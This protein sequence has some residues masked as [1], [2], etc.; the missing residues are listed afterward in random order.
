MSVV[1]VKINPEM[2]PEHLSPYHFTQTRGWSG[3]NDN[4][5]DSRNT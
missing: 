3:V 2:A 1:H 4:K 5:K